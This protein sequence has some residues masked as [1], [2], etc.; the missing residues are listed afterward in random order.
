MADK[1]P[2][3]MPHFLEGEIKLP[4]ME[5]KVLAFWDEQHTFEKSLD[6]TADGKPFTFYDGPPF[7][8]GLPHYGH[9]LAST[10]K[11]VIPRYQTMNGRY[12]RRRWGWDC[13]G[14]PIEEVV[15]RKLGISGKKQIEEI[16][17]K[18]F[19]ETCRSM[20]LQYVSEWR[21]MI[22]R[23]ARWVDFDDSYKT[24][25]ADF[26]ESVWWGFKQMYDKDLI[27]EGR[28]VLLYCPRCETPLS[29]FEVAMDNS[30]K[31]VTEESVTARFKMKSAEK[32]G[33]SQ[34]SRV[35]LLAWTT[36]PWTLPGNV[37]LAVG[38]KILYTVLRIKGAEDLYVVANE[39]VQK[40]FKDREIEIVRDNIKGTDLVGFEY[41]PL[42]DVPAMQSGTSYKVYPA[43]FVTTED[44]TGI[45]HTA[46]VYGEDDYNLGLKIGLPVVPMLDGRGLFNEKAPEFLRGQYFKKADKLV[47]ADL[48]KR[49]FLFKKEAY[50]HS[51]PHCWRCGTALF[52]NAIP[53]WFV[54]IQKIKPGLLKTNQ[55]EMN[56]FPEHLKNGRY[57]K[58]VEAAPD[59]N[60]SRN[61]YWGNPVPVWKCG[62]CDGVE[63]VGSME[64]L[65]QKAGGAK[66]NYWVMRHG[67]AES[68]MFDI[69]DSG[70]R[71]YLHLTP[72]G[73]EQ[74]LAAAEKFKK[75]LAREHKKI[76]I[77]ITSDITRT[78]DTEHIVASVL[79]GEEELV[80][81]RLEEIHLGPTFTGYRDEK[82][83]QEYPTLE[84]RFEH[85]PEGGESLRDVR[86][87]LWG[88]LD[89]CEK[90][91][92]G[93]NILLISHDYPIWM[94][95]HAAEAWSE[96]RAIEENKKLEHGFIGFAEVRRLDFKAVPRNDT[97]EA[98]LHRPYI[99]DITFPCAECGG[100]MKRTP[101]IFDSWIEAGSMPFAEYHYPFENEKEFKK[102]FP[103]QFVAEYIAQTR[104]WFYLSHVVSYILFGHAPF[105][106]VVTTGT[107]LAEDGSK[108]SKSK[109]NFPDPK[110]LIDKFGADSLRFYLMNSVVM[111]ADNLNFSEKGVES[112]YRKVGLLLSN[113]YKYFATYRGE[114]IPEEAV[115]AGDENI[116]DQWIMARTEELVDV[117]TRSL[118]AYDTVHA[119][120]A[121]QEYVDDLSTWYLRRSR[122]RKDAGFFKTMRASLLTTSRVLAPFMPFLAEAIYLEL[123]PADGAGSVHLEAWPKTEF[124]LGGK[125]RKELM[126]NMAEIRRLASLGLAARAE[127]KIKVRQ[128]LAKLTVR[129]AEATMRDARLLEILKS[130]VN[131]KEIVFVPE[132]ANEVELDTVI[133]PA[134][135]EEGLVRE[136]ARMFQE[137]RQKAGLEP[138]DRIVAMMELPEKTMQ[139]IDRNEASFLA[140]IGATAMEFGRSEKFIAEEVTKLEGE[141]VWVAIR[142]A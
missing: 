124:S 6:A 61:R 12:V 40:V 87:R 97:G 47:I 141:S 13:H 98:D 123:A 44:G 55:E 11:D 65:S 71:K 131:I 69:I 85:R 116:L 57:A 134:L 56:W 80:D 15:E 21:Q 37:A 51:Y 63:A 140:D 3:H 74:A 23:I 83:A 28:K 31:D 60:I 36:T 32:L 68:N 41:E 128:P 119:T 22:R 110:L 130:E 136:V 52:Y 113:V 111:Q 53:A 99:D 133:T 77:I 79:T 81:T 100:V 132:L 84:S 103:A 121:I 135:R 25:D 19:N 88:F 49:D 30:Y 117:V 58:S 115:A 8:T 67:E 138:K 122:K 70:Q 94:M 86:M 59:W 34:D 129:G 108:M 106:N 72:R 50:T 4:E 92:K 82:Y 127:A 114:I 104:A 109:N 43:D 1:T 7:A 45:V 16:G 90:K 76:D 112:V 105:E 26:M 18:K 95:T 54:N 102:H 62:G 78:K 29:N 48:E 107:I 120:R 75:E 9:L 139:V 125:E 17:I 118:D 64:E 142:K 2:H 46:V 66:N 10:I 96:K 35:Y 5:E 137:L 101:E 24:L 38:E 27:Y 33:L 91:Y 20:V 14:L 73:K 126:E 89:D 42:F 93:K 39:L